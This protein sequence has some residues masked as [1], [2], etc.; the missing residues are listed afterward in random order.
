MNWTIRAFLLVA[1]LL[2]GCTKQPVKACGY[3]NTFVGYNSGIDNMEC[4]EHDD[5]AIGA[6]AKIAHGISAATEIGPGL[7]AI[8]GAV[9]INGVVMGI[10]SP[11]ADPRCS[12]EVCPVGDSE[13]VG[14]MDGTKGK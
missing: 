2:T 8:E 13:I 3:Q 1:I 5:T 12:G 10:Q 9:C 4:N 11:V 14:I 7:C 6:N